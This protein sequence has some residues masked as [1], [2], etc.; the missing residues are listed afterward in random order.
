MSAVAIEDTSIEP[1]T[2]CAELQQRARQIEEGLQNKGKANAAAQLSSDALILLLTQVGVLEEKTDDNGRSRYR[3]QLKVWQRGAQESFASLLARLDMTPVGP[4]NMVLEK[5]LGEYKTGSESSLLGTKR[6]EILRLLKNELGRIE[7]VRNGN[8]AAASEDREK[9][10]RLVDVADIWIPAM[11]GA[12]SSVAEHSGEIEK[13]RALAE[14]S[15]SVRGGDVGA[16]A[17]YADRLISVELIWQK[18]NAHNAHVDSVGAGQGS[19][20][21]NK[22]LSDADLDSPDTKADLRTFGKFTA[23]LLAPLEKHCDEFRAL[24]YQE[25]EACLDRMSKSIGNNTFVSIGASGG[26][27]GAFAYAIA[28]REL[29]ERKL[30]TVGLIGTTDIADFTMRLFAPYTLLVLMFLSLAG[31][32]VAALRADQR[33]LS[34]FLVDL[35]PTIATGAIFCTFLCLCLPSLAGSKISFWLL[36]TMIALVVIVIGM[37]MYAGKQPGVYLDDRLQMGIVSFLRHCSQPLGLVIVLVAVGSILFTSKDVSVLM[38]APL[39]SFRE[40]VSNVLAGTIE[41]VEIPAKE[42][43]RVLESKSHYVPF[44]V[45]P[46]FSRLSTTWIVQQPSA[47]SSTATETQS[48]EERKDTWLLILASDVACVRPPTA[49]ERVHGAALETICTGKPPTPS[50]PVTF[51]ANTIAGYATQQWQCESSS[52]SQGVLATISFGHQES[53][54]RNADQVAES[55]KAPTGIVR[56]VNANTLTIAGLAGFAA[57]PTA[58]FEPRSLAD[59]IKASPNNILVVLGFANA[60]GS[61]DY[62]LRLSEARAELLAGELRDQ[63]DNN[64]HLPADELM[65]RMRTIGLGDSNLA[66]LFGV[67]DTE[68]ERRAVAFV[69]EH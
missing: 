11:K 66:G 41:A 34:R 25:A 65:R 5:F 61:Q 3:H 53:H 67:Q 10:R 1:C 60:R 52:F 24:P 43:F 59:R 32:F 42:D 13:W 40:N 18:L 19:G 36:G 26:V 8:H 4:L 29:D 16:L 37:L 51:P 39:D 33:A 23:D 68:M 9:L 44:T 55:D 35:I 50:A 57:L 56:Q 46:G 17:S 69:C 38:A 12:G 14:V 63:L 22:P 2:I 7:S 21:S 28:A 27:I 58:K 49:K 48:A 45:G 15:R 62:N 31:M 6:E 64:K 30:S 54:L 20:D 47:N